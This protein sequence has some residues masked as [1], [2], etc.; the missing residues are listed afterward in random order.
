MKK[1]ITILLMLVTIIA[2]VDKNIEQLE[3]DFLVFFPELCKEVRK[4]VNSEKISH[5]K[6]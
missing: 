2:C 5:W 3:K 1:S 6:N 4:N